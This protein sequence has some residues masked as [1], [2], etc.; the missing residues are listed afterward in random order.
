MKNNEK[1]VTVFEKP[2]SELKLQDPTSSGKTD[3]GTEAVKVVEITAADGQPL[4]PVSTPD[5]K[6][7]KGEFVQKEQEANN[8][9]QEQVQKV[10]A[11]INCDNNGQKDQLQQDQK[12]DMETEQVNCSE[13]INI[14]PQTNQ[15]SPVEDMEEDLYEGFAAPPIINDVQIDD[16]ITLA[17]TV[18]SVKDDGN[19][20]KMEGR[21]EEAI[22]GTMNVENLNLGDIRSEKQERNVQKG[23][24]VDEQSSDTQQDSQDRYRIKVPKDDEMV[25]NQRERRKSSKSSKYDR[26]RDDKERKKRKHRSYSRSR[27]RSP[28]ERRHSTRSYRTKKYDYDTS[29]DRRGQRVKEDKD[30]TRPARD[31][32]NHQHRSKG[33]K[34]SSHEKHTRVNN[35]DERRKDGQD[36]THV[37][38][39]K[40]KDDEHV[41]R[42][43]DKETNE[44]D[45]GQ[46]PKEIDEDNT[47]S[48]RS[49]EEETPKGRRVRDEDDERRRR[50]SP[51]DDD[52]R[53]KRSPDD[54]D[55]RRRRSPDDDGKHRRRTPDVEGKHRRRSPEDD[56]KRRRRSPIDE[57]QR[58]RRPRSEERRS[59][60]NDG[61]HRQRSPEDDDKRRK[62]SPV[63]EDQRRRR[64]R[65]EERRS[66]EDEGKHRRR[67]PEDDDKR[68][69]RS[70]DDEDQRRRRPR[71][72]ERE[73]YERKRRSR[74]D[75]DRRGRR[76]RDEDNEDYKRRHS[77]DDDND[78]RR[79]RR[80]KDGYD[81]YR[82]DRRARDDEDELRRRRRSRDLAERGYQDDSRSYGRE[83]Q[84]DF[85]DRSRERSRERSLERSRRRDVSRSRSWSRGSRRRF[86]DRD[87]E[88]RRG[89]VPRRRSRSR[90]E[91]RRGG[92][93]NG[94]SIL[95]TSMGL[96]T[97]SGEGGSGQRS[98]EDQQL[99]A[100]Q[101]V[102]EQQAAS[103]AAAASKTQREVYVGNLAY[104]LVNE[105]NL[106][107]LFNNALS[108][109]F[110]QAQESGVV[111]INKK[112]VVNVSM[113]SDGRYAFVELQTPEMATAALQ[114]CGQVSLMGQQITVGRPSGYIDPQKAQQAALL[115][116]QALAKFKEEHK[117]W[118]ER[119]EKRNE[120]QGGRAGSAGSGGSSIPRTGTHFVRP[121]RERQESPPV[122]SQ[123]LCI[124]GAVTPKVLDS[125]SEYEETIRDLHRECEKYGKVQEVRIPRPTTEVEDKGS[126]LGTDNYGRAYVF[127][128]NALGAI[129]AK[130]G[131]QGR[132]FA[133]TRLDVEFAVPSEWNAAK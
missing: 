30:S 55:K 116:S 16:I 9:E 90:S 120:S 109:A 81:E 36:G 12:D 50:R 41:R 94:S 131:I 70:P 78:Y 132:S 68:R 10:Q 104:G 87:W 133:G 46:R 112:P 121:N 42:A 74:Y 76:L 17:K 1:Q 39:S 75:E 100:R 19:L 108:A 64:P 40:D 4:N 85:R 98:Q 20:K 25:E 128:E 67:S 82:R 118:L 86:F 51:D 79:R 127:F 129:R 103:A 6:Q 122:L 44:D 47:R 93:L 69:R 53:R 3:T 62:R 83:K 7:E 45:R 37:Q 29:D 27:S 2:S 65:S 38:R 84:R 92:W 101:L 99:L 49:K 56:D 5:K 57:D 107:E 130:S 8:S 58:R 77:K 61:K 32:D 111:N 63:D 54:D 124:Y 28:R 60:D 105:I 66:P 14:P 15:E 11:P 80:S 21:V 24:L 59:P 106:A 34:S 110:P 71:S 33:D 43:K 115:A 97:R 35:E 73:E 89:Y 88:M 126:Y 125:D 31:D 117:D 96:P 23:R 91:S 102:L 26:D 18:E 52:K 48:R 72:E 119:Q 95:N 114:L 22:D 113:H 123:Y 13:K